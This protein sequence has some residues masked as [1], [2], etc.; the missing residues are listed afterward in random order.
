VNSREVQNDECSVQNEKGQFF[1]L[2]FAF[3][4]PRFG[5]A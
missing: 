1:I 2:D 3:I 5:F 4:I